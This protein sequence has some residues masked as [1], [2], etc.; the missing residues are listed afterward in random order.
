[1]KKISRY[2]ILTTTILSIIMVSGLISSISEESGVYALSPYTPVDL[3]LNNNFVTLSSSQN[4]CV[5]SGTTN[6]E[7]VII[8][9]DDLNI[10]NLKVNVKNDSFSYEIKDIP[11]PSNVLKSIEKLNYTEKDALK[12]KDIT[13]DLTKVEVEAKSIK[14]SN[15]KKESFTIKKVMNSSEIEKE[16]KKACEN[17]SFSE[18]IERN[19]YNFKGFKTKYSGKVMNYNHYDYKDWKYLDDSQKEES[20]FSKFDLAIDGNPNQII[21][22]YC[23]ENKPMANGNNPIE[24]GDT[25]TVWCKIGGDD[26]YSQTDLDEWMTYSGLDL[27]GY[28]SYSGWSFFYSSLSGNDPMYGPSYTSLGDYKFNPYADVWYYGLE[29]D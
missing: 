28:G 27:G 11:I 17:I 20:A 2:L 5:I 1:M 19:P 4:S 24:N 16:F 9:C 3:H 12:K 22:L 26:E 7:Y 15:D 10:I 13:I 14:S 23:R 21:K 18:L 6:A 25:I 8:N 29:N